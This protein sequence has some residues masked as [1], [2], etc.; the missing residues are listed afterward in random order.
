MIISISVLGNQQTPSGYVTKGGKKDTPGAF[1]GWLSCGDEEMGVNTKSGDSRNGDKATRGHLL[2]ASGRSVNLWEEEE[3]ENADG[4]RGFFYATEVSDISMLTGQRTKQ[5]GEKTPIRESSDKLLLFMHKW[6]LTL[7][8][9]LP[10][11]N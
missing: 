6:H 9:F 10:S 3:A 2:A 7:L 8:R 1:G 5:K 11:E 4:H